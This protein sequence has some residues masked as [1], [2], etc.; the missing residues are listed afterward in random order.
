[1]AKSGNEKAGYETKV[2][3]DKLVVKV[4]CW[5]MWDAALAEAY[6]V[7]LLADFAQVKGRQWCVLA[8]ISQ[9]PPQREEV[10][11]VHGALMGQAVGMGMTKAASVVE[12]S[13]S[14]MLISRIAKESGMP[15]LAFHTTEA[16]ALSWLLEEKAGA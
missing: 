10:Q 3:L 11:A 14:K 4:R 6:R 1:M 2:D 16:S 15:E 12:S 5:G 7:D 9:F 13:L 8:D